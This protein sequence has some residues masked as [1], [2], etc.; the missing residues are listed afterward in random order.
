MNL[1]FQ[2]LSLPLVH[3]YA[4]ALEWAGHRYLFHGLGKK[5]GSIFGFHYAEHH[6]DVRRQQGLDA[7]YRRSPLGWHAHGRECIGIVLLGLIH[8]PLAFAAP[9]P[10]A[11]LMWR[12]F[13][14]HRLHRKSH[15]DVA[16]TQQHLPWH[17]D[18][19]MGPDAD[20]NWC[21]TCEWFDKLM[22]TRKPWSK[23]TSSVPPALIE[24]KSPSP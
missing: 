1:A 4:T 23:R 8:L 17:W 24:G 5:K 12:G 2:L 10:Y 18:H 22:G 15:V 9:L 20:A 19:H 7:A 21:V 13:E 11:Y 14:Y 16:W 6:R 3:L